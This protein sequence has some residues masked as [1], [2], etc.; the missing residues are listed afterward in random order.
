MKTTIDALK[1]RTLSGPDAILDALRPCMGF[2]DQDLLT[3]SDREDGKDGWLFRR[4]LVIAGDALLGTI[5]YAGEHM[6]GVVRVNIP[7]SGCAWIQDWSVIERLPK[8]LEKATIMRLDIALTTYQGEVSHERVIAAHEAREF[9]TGGR[10]PHR[11]ELVGSDPLAGRTVY[12]GNR[13]GAKYLRAYEKGWEM[14]KDYPASVRQFIANSMGLIQVDGIGHRDPAKIYRVEVEFK[15][16][17]RRVVPWEAI[18]KRD[19]YF[20]GAYPFCASLLPGVQETRIH[21]L[22]EVG[23]KLALASAADHCRR[24]YG[25]TIRALYMAYGNN[26]KRV[27]DV[28]MSDKPAEQLI[29]AGVLLVDHQDEGA[30]E[31]V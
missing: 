12:V 5:D 27:L 11:R 4:N 6:R 19:E 13:K 31:G 30:R 9:C 7:G 14:L 21:A 23:A 25:K 24:S 2:I 8:V 18:G 3:L 22:P 17:D 15:D 16:E 20:A 28:L 1:F 26:A 29:A 10:H